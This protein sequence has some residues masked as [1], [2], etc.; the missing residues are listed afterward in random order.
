MPPNGGGEGEGGGGRGREGEGGGE[1][2]GGRG[3]GGGIGPTMRQGGIIKNSSNSR[4]SQLEG[5]KC[6]TRYALSWHALE[7]HAP[8]YRLIYKYVQHSNIYLC[9][10]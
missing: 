1:G 5:A 4:G 3:E 10:A 9:S 2:G 8:R 6:N 7:R